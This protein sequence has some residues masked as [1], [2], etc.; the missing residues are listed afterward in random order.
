MKKLTLFSRLFSLALDASGTH[1]SIELFYESMFMVFFEE[2]HI[3]PS[4]SCISGIARGDRLLP[5]ELMQYYWDPDRPRCPRK[6]HADLAALV[7]CCYFDSLRAR[8][9]RHALEDF[10]LTIP[11]VDAEDLRQIIFLDDLPRAWAMLVWYALC[12][13]AQKD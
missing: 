13:D 9:L 12:V 5:K 2:N 7:Y 6:L 10:L 8:A 4:S 3:Q 1:D 11:E